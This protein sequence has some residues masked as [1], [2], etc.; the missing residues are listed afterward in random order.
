MIL[1]VEGLDKSGKSTIIKDLVEYKRQMHKDPIVLKLS[2]KPKDNSDSEIQK[3]KII[4]TELFE[5]AK[6]LQTD[7]LVLFDRSFPSEMVYSIKRGYD[8]MEDLFWWEFD[9]VLG[10]QNLLEIRTILIYCKAPKTVLIERFKT[11][12]EE[13]VSN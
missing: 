1:I 5:Q 3:V 7:R 12:K 11:D 6:R 10:K 2:Q 4:Y 8:A 13:W 9:R